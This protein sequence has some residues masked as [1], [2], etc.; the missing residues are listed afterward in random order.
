MAKSANVI[1]SLT[2]GKC[3]EEVYECSGQNCELFVCET[4]PPSEDD[5][6]VFAKYGNCTNKAAQLSAL[7]AILRYATKRAYELED[8]IAE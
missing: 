4:M 3:T 8:E 2:N 1:M 6:C 7:R 5:T